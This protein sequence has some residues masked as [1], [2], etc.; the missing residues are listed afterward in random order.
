M[1]PDSQSA[2]VL[3]AS[4][5]PRRW[6][7]LSG[8]LAAEVLILCLPVTWW[9]IA[10]AVLL[11]VIL[12]FSL[13]FSV[14][15]G[16][17]EVPLLGW[18]LIFPLGYHFLIFPQEQALIT[19]DRTLIA[20]L[21]LAAFFAQRNPP[22]ITVSSSSLRKSAVWWVIFLLG[23]ALTIPQAKSPLSSLH[24]VID[25]LALPG[26]LAWYVLRYFDV[27]K[28]LSLL[29][30]FTCLMSMY[31]A[32]IAVME[33]VLQRDLLPVTGGALYFAGDY[34]G[35]GR[36]I[37]IRPN[38]P[39]SSDNS[40]AI[41]GL[42]SFFLILFL[43]KASPER[44]PT[45][46]TVL[47]RMGLAA[48]LVS[49]LLPMFRSVVIALIAAVVIDVFYQAGRR[50]VARFAILFLFA[51]GFLLLRLTLPDVFEERTDPEHVYGRVAQYQQSF[52]MFLD[53]PLTG[54]GL[55]NF[56]EAAQNSKYVMYYQGYESVDSPHSNLSAVLAE[57][58]IIGFVPFIASQVFLVSAF[59]RRRRI[60]SSDSTLVW[61]TFLFVFV[62]WWLN[63][64]TLTI[65]Y[66]GDSNMWYLFVLAVLYKFAVTNEA[67]PAATA[68]LAPPQ[69]LR[70]APQR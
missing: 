18:A 62:G 51:G 69:G 35:E 63:G 65:L 25:A 37:L 22:R 39:F 1:S 2:S 43:K 10:A 16:R 40:L 17:G 59:W 34:S 46:Q 28:H 58:G 5:S 56:G 60:Q 7:V 6:L 66:A 68:P 27:R 19:A 31:V 32:A 9:G 12:F 42:L 24:V 11:G 57:T 14:I 61:K 64:L 53:H 67:V 26:V 55:N 48:A 33:V 49:A 45:W 8:I 13:V 36:E 20:L 23:A 15:Q 54:V 3:L 21:L 30:A 4:P 47:H 41:V 38:G 52:A 70:Y 50:R 44:M 29:H